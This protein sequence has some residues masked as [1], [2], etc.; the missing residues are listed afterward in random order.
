LFSGAK[1]L[2][3]DLEQLT[4]Q[5]GYQEGVSCLACHSI[6]QTD[7]KGNA[8]FVVAKPSRYLFEGSQGR[9]GRLAR[10][11][12]IRAYP[13]QHTAELSKRMFKAPEY[14]AA[15]H[16]QFIDQEVNRV[17]WVQLQNQ[18][19]NWK[20]SRWNHPDDPTRTLEC[21]E[22]HMPLVASS[23]PAAGDEADFNRTDADGMHR[24][25]RFLGANQ[26]IPTYHELE[27]AEE[28]VALTERWLRG[29]LDVPEIADRW[30]AGPAVPIELE[31]PEEVRPGEG[32]RRA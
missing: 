3:V 28:H 18:Y 29:E 32:A 27:G 13:W 22:C 9:G 5:H 21:R 15:C 19:D 4:S 26:F 31:V 8:S 10:D 11:F 17:G 20:A 12:L 14:C 6:R 1:N 23:D 16:K 24:S 7:V 30:R 25:H 2:F